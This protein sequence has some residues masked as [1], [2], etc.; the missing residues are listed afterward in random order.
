MITKL[1][2]IK[3]KK[4]NYMNIYEMP[5][6]GYA[7]RDFGKNCLQPAPEGRTNMMHDF[8]ADYCLVCLGEFD[9]ETGKI[10]ALD[11]PKVIAEASQ[12]VTSK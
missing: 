1:F 11:E 7:V 3:D 8:P 4:S 10:T 9:N 2:A 6:E 12:Y 5:N